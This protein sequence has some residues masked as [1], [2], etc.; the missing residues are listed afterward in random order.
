MAGEVHCEFA[1][2]SRNLEVEAMLITIKDS[3]TTLAKLLVGRVCINFMSIW[4]IVGAYF[5]PFSPYNAFNFWF[6]FIEDFIDDSNT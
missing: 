2:N 4:C 5:C 3:D 6:L 1:L